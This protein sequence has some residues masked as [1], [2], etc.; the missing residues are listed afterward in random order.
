MDMRMS[1][2]AIWAQADAE[3]RHTTSAECREVGLRD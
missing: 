1:I 3:G 2:E